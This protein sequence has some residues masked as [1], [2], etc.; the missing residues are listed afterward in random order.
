MQPVRGAAEV[1][2][3]TETTT[4]RVGRMTPAGEVTE[5]PLPVTGAFPS[6]I[7]AGGKEN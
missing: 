1:Q 6:A 5:Y 3:F 2:L 7:A 4:D